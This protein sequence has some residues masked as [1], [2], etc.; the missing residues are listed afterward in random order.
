MARCFGLMYGLMRGRDKEGSSLG[1]GIVIGSAV[2]A[3]GY[4]GWLPLVGLGK[5]IWK[6]TL[7]EFG[8]ELLRHVAYGVATAASYKLIDANI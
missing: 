5:P 2:Y 8:G 7:P 6:Q 3:I 4:V 1:D